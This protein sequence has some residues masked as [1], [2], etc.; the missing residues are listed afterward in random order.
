MIDLRAAR[1]LLDFGARMGEGQRAEEQLEGAVAIHNLLE[2]EGVAYLA[3]EVGMGKTYVALGALALFRHY[4]PNFRVLVLAPKENI[5]AKW[6]KELRNFVSHNVRF[7]DMRVKNIDDRP[8]RPLV[9]CNSLLEF[10]NS[11]TRNADRDFF[12]RL[13]SFSLPVAGRHTPD[14]KAVRQMRDRFREY[15]PWLRAEAFDLRSKRDLKDNFAR[16]VCCA[17][18]EFD[19]VIVDEGHNLKH[20]LGNNVAARN[21]VLSLAMG[22]E[23]LTADRRMFPQFAP[24]AK[25]VLFLSATPV[26]DTYQQLWNQLDV[27]GFAENYL[28][29]VAKDADEEAK[30]AEASR[31]LIRRVTSIKIGQKEHTKNLYRREWRRGGVHVH[32]EPIRV[33]DPRQ[34]LVVALVQKKVTELLG[35]ERFNSSFQIGMLASFE[36]F[37]ETAKVKSDDADTS[38]FDDADQTDNTLEKEGVDVAD[39]NRL[40]RSYRQKFESEMPHPKMDAL[41]DSLAESWTRG[42]KSLVFVRRVASVKELKQKL[43]ER[44]NRWL[45]ERLQRDLVPAIRD[46]LSTQYE[47][48]KSERIRRSSTDWTRS[49]AR[50][51]D[52]KG[53]LDTFFAW[54]FRG[55]GPP[56]VVSGATI[57]RRFIQQGAAYATFFERNYVSELLQVAPNEVPTQL[58]RTLDVTMERLAPELRRRSAR[59]LSRAEKLA[60]GDRFKAVQAAAVEWLSGTEGPL[61]QTAR[62]VWHERFESSV[63]VR[64][65]ERAPDIGDWLT[66]RT[67]F[68]E[69]LD[70]KE[71]RQRL[72][73]TP[74]QSDERTAFREQELRAQLLASAAR[75]GHAL[76][77]LYVMTVN[78]IG[79]L[80]P[81]QQETKS[82]GS[83]AEVER[84]H[85]YIRLLDGQR[86]MPLAERD[87]SAFDEL[88][89]VADHFELIIDVNDPAARQRPLIESSLGFGRLLRQQQPV[90]GM[91]GQV[92]QTLVRQFRMPGYPFL[93]VT[94]DLL[95]EGEDLHTFCS[96]VHHYGISWTPSAMEQRIGRV[97]RVRSQTDR[98]LSQLTNELPEEH[99]LQVYFPHLEDTVEV[100]QV[101]RVL[102]RMNSFLRLMHEGLTATSAGDGTINTDQEFARVREVV[103]PIR[104]QLKTAF[105]IVRDLLIGNTTEL[106]ES[107]SLAEELAE[108]FKKLQTTLPGLEVT[109]ERQNSIARLLGTAK[110][111]DRV[112]PFA[113]L[114]QAFK[115]RPLVR[116]VSPIGR[117]EPEEWA[118]SIV[119]SAC[120]TPTKIGAI[121]GK[122]DMQYDLTAEGEVLLADP[123]SDLHRVA[124]LVRRVVRQADD[125][126]QEH[127]PDVDGPMSEFENDLSSEGTH[128]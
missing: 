97:D 112:Q 83:D 15:L 47:K 96:S 114:L 3:D 4:Q 110:L 32:D 52:D 14:R 113:L 6:M 104:E 44:Y 90:G 111:G 28:K 95:Q 58:C 61:Q 31:F 108:R 85:E 17:L 91:S 43:D 115:S 11:A 102:E 121:V 125:F 12:L 24:R 60:R 55:E 126:E 64:H 50:G 99:K 73:P 26:E 36:S 105:P 9:R 53:G 79:T 78:R 75:L 22:N 46:E 124:I 59:F 74:D 10:V 1:Q 7:A 77:D 106:A 128:E 86:V 5:Q 87:W 8:A 67:F 18:P 63:L 94:T 71:L 13:T 84:I 2:R 49:A 101:Q 82:T 109:W 25:R 41:V 57:Q 19:L 122:Q 38:N 34:R 93:L 120:R 65:T 117:I 54:F 29:L 23:A 72:W 81:R 30:K 56:D 92:N 62:I 42:K 119:E 68:T 51:E 107:E 103:E 37:L 20:G 69:I 66:T 70:H 88:A 118:D 89:E 76:I 127:L 33:E 16:A 116:C 100:L 21:R 35:H 80:E 98:R 123:E 27:F 39:I 48:Y 45:L 40:A